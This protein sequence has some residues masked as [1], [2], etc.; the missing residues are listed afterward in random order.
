GV[1]EKV[2]GSFGPNGVGRNR[3]DSDDIYVLVAN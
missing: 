2:V 1:F 3:Y